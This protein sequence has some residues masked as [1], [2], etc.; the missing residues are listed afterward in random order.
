VGWMFMVS[1]PL[2][3]TQSDME[4]ALAGKY[5][6]RK[7]RYELCRLY[8]DTFSRKPSFQFLDEKTTVQ[9]FTT[10]FEHGF[11]IFAI[12]HGKLYGA[13]LALPLA[14]DLLVPHKILS[15]YSIRHSFYIA[16]IMVSEMFQGQG[17]GRKLIM[18]FFDEVNINEYTNVFIRVWE[19]NKPA[20][21]L[22]EKMGFKPLA[23][24][25]Q[26]KL[27]ADKSGMYNF[28]K[29][30]MLKELKKEFVNG[31]VNY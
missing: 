5:Y 6:Y 9:Y 3:L 13:L 4:Y 29:I 30:Y 8:I 26:T 17:I 21:K 11:G 16:E 10:V 28:R 14:F 12:K 7:Y 22:Y 1:F 18:N 25:I 24:I 27:M 20:I 31:A 15:K 2:K 23:S 19:K